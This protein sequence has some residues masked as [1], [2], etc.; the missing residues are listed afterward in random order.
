MHH[1]AYY[2]EMKLNRKPDE[3]MIWNIGNQAQCIICRYGKKE[4]YDFFA[5]YHGHGMW[6]LQFH[7]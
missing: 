7:Y 5:P 3:I 2:E 1:R 4:T 6:D